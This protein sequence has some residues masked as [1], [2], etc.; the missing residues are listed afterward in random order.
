MFLSS[1]AI[2]AQVLTNNGAQITVT[3]G[4]ILTVN[5]DVLNSIGNV[6]NAGYVLV[7]GSV[8]NN[9][10]ITGF[11]VGTGLYEVR[12]N[13]FNNSNFTADQSTVLL[14]G[15]NQIIGGLNQSDF[16][17]L[18]LDGTGIKS[19]QVNS[20]VSNQ[21]ELNNVELA[22]DLY[23]MSVS[24]PQV[25]SIGRGT[26][27]V[28]SLGDG[29]LY[30]LTNS[31]GTYLFPTGSSLGTVRYRPAE[32]TPN[33][34][35]P[36]EFGARLVNN[37][38]NLDGWD[39][40]IIDGKEL[41]SI[42]PRFYH[43]LYKSSGPSASN[44]ALYFDPATDGE[45]DKMA[46][47]QTTP[48]WESMGTVANVNNAGLSGLEVS[49]WDSYTPRPFALGAGW[50]VLDAGMDQSIQ[51]GETA[52]LMANY[53]GAT[54]G[55]IEWTYS[56]ALTCYD[57][58]DPE[59][60]PASTSTF[61]ITVTDVNECRISDS[62]IVEVKGAQALIPNA[63]SPNNDGANDFFSVINRETL[64]ILEIKVFNR[65]GELVFESNA[66]DAAWNGFYKGEP[67]EMGVYMYQIEYSFVEDDKLRYEKGDVTL[68]R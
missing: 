18:T 12:E 25:N 16:Y 56:P 36:H 66:L 17:N 1:L 30:R 63:F 10:N 37:D 54:I 44:L 45:W 6:D 3:N 19:Q 51:F 14:N 33:S 46:H 39:R 20:L 41:C 57:C 9:D 21:L 28:S 24:N 15:G 31:T 43:Y 2:N 8:T 29:A 13:W 58:L 52:D 35:D 49:N 26:G 65:W 23:D 34:A 67:Q 59:A 53:V 48:R 62:L 4:G 55:T 11:G 5:G 50:P 22:T 68:V 27:F 40:D 7:N 61:I 32:F 38:P 60:N 64:D 42:N 47:W